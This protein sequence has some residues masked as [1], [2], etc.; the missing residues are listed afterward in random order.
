[1]GVRGHHQAEGEGIRRETAYGESMSY[2]VRER[3]TQGSAQGSHSV[4]GPRSFKRSLVIVLRQCV[5]I[6][7]YMHTHLMCFVFVFYFFFEIESGFVAQAR[8][9]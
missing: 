2:D 8:V 3:E 7:V 5:C 4:F 1:M 6:Y 9:Q